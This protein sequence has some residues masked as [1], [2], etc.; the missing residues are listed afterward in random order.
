MAILPGGPPPT[1][2]SNAFTGTGGL[3]EFMGNG[4]WAGWSGSVNATQGTDGILFEFGSP[5]VSLDTTL[6]IMIDKTGLGA[7]QE[8]GWNMEF[9]DVTVANVTTARSADMGN[10]DLDPIYFIIPARTT[11]KITAYTDD[12]SN[13]PFSAFIRAHEI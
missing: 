11:V 6:C 2:S 1:G 9:S 8:W 13:I 7:G 5:Q 4:Y 12:S 10:V 3:I